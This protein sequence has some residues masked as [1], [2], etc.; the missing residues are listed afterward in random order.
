MEQRYEKEW[1]EG[2]ISNMY[3]SRR[4][5]APPGRYELDS[6][7][8]NQLAHLFHM[9]RTYDIRHLLPSISVPTLVIHLD[10]NRT[11]PA[12]HGEYIAGAIPGARL[13]LVPG[14]DHLFMRNYGGPVIDASR[15]SSWATCTR[16]SDR[17]RTTILFTDIVDST[18][19]AAS[20]GDDGGAR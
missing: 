16:F 20:L 10:E 8:H 11:I 17:L 3:A 2:R 6:T 4:G 12:V 18:R 1:G 15:S 19:L 7:S 14:T 13:V 9:N 5:D